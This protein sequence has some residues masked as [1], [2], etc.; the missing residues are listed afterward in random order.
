MKTKTILLL[1]LVTSKVAFSHGFAGHMGH[2][3]SVL[4][5]ND[6]YTPLLQ[7]FFTALFSQTF[8]TR[9]NT[10]LSWRIYIPRFGIFT[11]WGLGFLMVGKQAC[12]GWRTRNSST[13]WYQSELSQS[14]QSEHDNQVR[15][16]GGK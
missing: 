7:I 1:M 16:A 2:L 14:V 3:S 8:N 6:H 4:A 12:Y 9:R 5:L 11:E 10:N 13:V 15:F